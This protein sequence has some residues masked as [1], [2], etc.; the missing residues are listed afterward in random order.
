MGLQG[1]AAGAAVVD[2]GIGMNHSSNR[3]DTWHMAAQG[4][5]GIITHRSHA[6]PPRVTGCVG[7]EAICAH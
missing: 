7:L 4:G 3:K 5:L 1:G 6:Q 2:K